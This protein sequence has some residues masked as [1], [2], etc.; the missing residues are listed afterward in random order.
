MGDT[1]PVL[2]G[3]GAAGLW[4]TADFFAKGVAE[5]EGSEAAL[6]WLYIVGLPLYVA[7]W[8]AT[9]AHLPS[10]QAA[11]WWSAA[12]LIN[13]FAYLALYRG[14]RIG[15]LAVVSTTN[16]AWAGITVV[17]SMLF[18]HERPGTLA[19]SG[20]GLTLA[21]VMLVAYPGGKF[22]FRAP[23]FREGLLS[24]VFFGTS[25]FLLKRPAASGDLFAQAAVMRGTGLVVVALAAWSRGVRPAAFLRPPPLFAFLDSAGFAAFVTGLRG[26]AAFIVAPLGSLLTPVAV[27]LAAVFLHERLLWHQWAGFILVVLGVL[28]LGPAAG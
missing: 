22:S 16:A 8:L 25:F 1:T 5:R 26:G 12:G 14:F 27:A 9:G 19:L 2:L 11:A 6:L 10:L 7:V 17:L 13:A 20:I 3:L 23:G 4:G 21:G 28:L 15:L 24:A 18:L